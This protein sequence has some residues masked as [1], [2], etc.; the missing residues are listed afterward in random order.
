M[1]DDIDEVYRECRDLG[2]ETADL[3]QL[4]H[5]CAAHF[6]LDVFPFR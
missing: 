5:E 2:E 1:G 4:Y 6:V 3:L